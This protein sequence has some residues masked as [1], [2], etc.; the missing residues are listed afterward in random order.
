MFG[1]NTKFLGL[2][3][4]KDYRFFVIFKS[5]NSEIRLKYLHHIGQSLYN[6]LQDRLDTYLICHKLFFK[7]N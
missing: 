4:S 2:K 7:D 3:N 6:S 5:E 1:Y